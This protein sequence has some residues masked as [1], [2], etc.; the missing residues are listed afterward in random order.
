MVKLKDIAEKAGVSVSTVSR[1]I[2]AD[3]ERPASKE[4]SDKIWALVK[5]LGYIPNQNAKNLVKG[6]IDSDK[7]KG[8]IGCIFTSTI[9]L[10]N[11]PFFSCIGLG[12]QEELRNQGYNLSYALST[13]NMSFSEI[14]NQIVSKPAQGVIVTGRFE[15]SVLDLLKQQFTHIVYTGVNAVNA[16]FDEVICDG[17]EG[18]KTALNHLFDRG[19]KRIGYIGYVPEKVTEDV[20]INEHRYK[21][22]CDLMNERSL[23][24]DEYQIIHTKLSTTE[25]YRNMLEYLEQIEPSEIPSAFYCANDATAFG[26]MKALREKNYR[27]PEDVALVGL[28]DVEMASFVTPSLSTISIPRKQ[29]GIRAVKVL[30]DQFETGRDYAMHIDIPY[31]LKIRESSNYKKP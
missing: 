12:I 20:L 16:G 10:N 27:I 25:A 28:D 4:T 30:V 21:A 17:Y 5:E 8:S 23:A 15:K 26:V 9:D 1:V 2:N 7:V 24:I 13:Y 31:K 22:Y 6:A 29:L 14:Y 11:D 3:R 19:H 18:A